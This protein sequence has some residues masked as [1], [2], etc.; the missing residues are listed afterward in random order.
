MT[1]KEAKF[2]VKHIFVTL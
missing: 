2:E 1:F